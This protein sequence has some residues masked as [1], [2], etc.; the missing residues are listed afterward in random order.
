MISVITQS[1]QIRDS[2]VSTLES[3]QKGMVKIIRL[4]LALALAGVCPCH[5]QLDSSLLQTCGNLP[6]PSPYF[7]S[8]EAFVATRLD[9]ACAQWEGARACCTPEDVSASLGALDISA[10]AT[11]HGTVGGGSGSCF[12]GAFD[13]SCADH[14]RWLSCATA[15]D[16]RFPRNTSTALP[17]ENVCYV[18][19]ARRN[20]IDKIAYA[21]PETPCDQAS[22]IQSLGDCDAVV[23]V[24]ETDIA[25]AVGDGQVIC[26]SLAT[27]MLRIP[28]ALLI[29][30]AIMCT[31]SSPLS[32][33]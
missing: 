6:A 16:I 28:A 25:V 33:S 11:M 12:M 24:G 32:L 26:Q 4:A 23:V 17:Q 5:G 8:L 9:S 14:L 30:V 7:A 21:D 1:H 29:L 13:A 27:R 18:R 15:C 31:L 3:R 20:G 19:H 10:L 2:R 22:Q